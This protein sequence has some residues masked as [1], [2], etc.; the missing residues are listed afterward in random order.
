MARTYPAG[1][2]SWVDLETPDAS[3]IAPF[4]AAVLGWT[5]TDAMPAAFQELVNGTKSPDQVLD[6][7]HKNYDD[8]VA[9]LDLDD[10]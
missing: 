10:D 3:E 7:L 2:S 8:G 5:L 9:Q 1:V 6:T 4:Y